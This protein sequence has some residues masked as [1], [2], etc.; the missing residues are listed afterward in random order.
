MEK[1]AVIYGKGR[2]MGATGL[3]LGLAKNRSID[4][5]CLLGATTGL[6]VDKEAGYNVFK[7]LMKTFGVEV[8]TENPTEKGRQNINN[9]I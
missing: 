7:F 5:A 8:A 1:G 3:L 6:R 4:G 2:I 9:T